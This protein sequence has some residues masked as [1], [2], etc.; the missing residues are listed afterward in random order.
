MRNLA[1]AILVGAVA[2]AACTPVAGAPAPSPTAATSQAAPNPT[3]PA[4]T[5]APPSAPAPTTT[6]VESLPDSMIGAWSH[7]A[8]A[9]WWFLRAGSP[10]CVAVARTD[11]DCVAYQLVGKPAYV[12]S[13]AMDGRLLRIRWVRGYCAGDETDF[14]TGMQ[15]DTL[16]L[17]D[18]EGDCGG[19]DFVLTR[20]GTGAA[21]T[22][23]PPPAS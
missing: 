1:I 14:G 10:T 16:R 12:G 20:A 19:D 22:A 23:P 18:T 13:A 3:P 8:P 5:K 17:F 4:A 6:A 2:T 9:F 21:P 11:L 7:P 15:G